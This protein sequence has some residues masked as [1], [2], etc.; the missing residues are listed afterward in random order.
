MSD[1]AN[2]IVVIC[3][4]PADV[5][6]AKGFAERVLTEKLEWLRDVPEDCAVHTT[7]TQ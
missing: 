6:V 7:A 4:A 3:E 5:R 2:C 1:F